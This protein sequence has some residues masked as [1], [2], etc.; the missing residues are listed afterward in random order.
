MLEERKR[1]V[2]QRD[3]PARRRLEIER[4]GVLVRLGDLDGALEVLAGALSSDPILLGSRG[5]DGHA[6]PD[7][8]ALWS[9]PRFRALIR[10]RG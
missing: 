3:A 6:D 10:P 9:D 5:E 7:L 8:A 1:G 4:A 2:M